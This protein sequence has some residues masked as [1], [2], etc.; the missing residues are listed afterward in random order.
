[1]S[2][3]THIVA[4]ADAR[5]LRTAAIGAALL[6]IVAAAAWHAASLRCVVDDAYI[7]FRYAGNLVAGHGL[8]FNPGERVDGYTNFLWTVLV[9]AGMACGASAEATSLGLGIASMA[10]LGFAT[11]ALG[12]AVFAWRWSGRL[13]ALA[14]L[15][16]LGPVLLWCVS[17]LETGLFAAVVVGALAAHVRGGKGEGSRWLPGLLFG[18]ATLVRPDGALFAS[19]AAAQLG[20]RAARA[21]PGDR[22]A[23]LRALA[24]F[25]AAFALV[26]AP[27]WWWRTW[28]YG[29]PLPNTFYAKTSSAAL[30]DLGCAYVRAFVGEYPFY[31]A[32]L[33]IGV[34]AAVSRDTP[35]RSRSPA[36][37]LV[38]QMVVWTGYVIRVG[39]D[40]MPLARVL[41]P[42]LPI[43][44]LF[45]TEA[46][47]VLGRFGA[48]SRARGAAAVAL[49]ACVAGTCLLPSY[50]SAHT[51][52]R[53]GLV[54]TVL[55]ERRK[56]AE[57]LAV[58]RLLR[59]VCP[60][61]TTLAVSNAGAIPYCS[62]LFAI[63]QSG[64]CDRYT[65]RVDSDPWV[66]DYPGHAIQATRAYLERRHPDLILWRPT[67]DVWRS[68]PLPLPPSP[69]YVTRA[70]RI[71]D[72][73]GTDGAELF[74]YLWV[75]RD[76]LPRLAE[77]PFLDL[78]KR[79]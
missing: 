72:L 53:L 64:L 43:G 44:A 67:I 26:V 31:V 42:V 63:D 54:D 1:M 4:G 18:V 78:S 23:T 21:H 32:A 46:C 15:A 11:D 41:V 12:T 74:L 7:S 9:G 79:P 33:A 16:A 14:L 75:R 5:R 28:Y 55:H 22:P 35:A 34:V 68:Q 19:V 57:W 45:A 20:V 48:G 66:L 40:Y 30:A 10:L 25:A 52:E 62:G 49:F 60:G 17:G 47:V 36:L 73:S 29:A 3:P 58:G 38:A 76:S 39:G 6:A 37:L 70:L 65:A 8:V 2:R 24:A 56:M 51:P 59:V 77:V 50:R 13:L 71:P 61:D 69:A 27:Y